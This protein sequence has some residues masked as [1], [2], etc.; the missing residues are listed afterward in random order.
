MDFGALP[1][2]VNSA[3]MY[4]GPGPGTLLTASAV[5]ESLAAELQSAA[6]GY[7]SAISGLTDES[8]MGPSAASMEAAVTPY[9]VWLRTTA[10]QCEEVADQAS[11]ATSAPRNPQA[12]RIR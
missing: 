2:E 6:G 11:A 1:P 4:L 3:R 10:A 12:A 9:L 8:W 7:Q 5:W